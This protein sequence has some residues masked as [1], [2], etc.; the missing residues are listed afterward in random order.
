MN[1]KKRL[2]KLAKMTEEMKIIGEE[3]EQQQQGQNSEKKIAQAIL[4]AQKMR[5]ESYVCSDEIDGIHT[6]QEYIG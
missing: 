6:E 4:D 2:A 5:E 3:Y 1:E